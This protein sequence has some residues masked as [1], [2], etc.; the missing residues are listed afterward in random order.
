MNEIK[1]LNSGYETSVKQVE[2]GWVYEVMP[3]ELYD[4][5]KK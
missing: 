5:P 3:K 2:H 4:K 1:S